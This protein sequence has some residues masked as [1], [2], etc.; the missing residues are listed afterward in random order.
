M[1]LYAGT[2]ANSMKASSMSKLCNSSFGEG[3][4][5]TL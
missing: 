2:G 3:F 1:I 5:E 4:Q